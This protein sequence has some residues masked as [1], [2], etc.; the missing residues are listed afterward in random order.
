M[1]RAPCPSCPW[2]TSTP[3]GAFPG[4]CLNS[5]RLLAMAAGDLGEPVGPDFYDHLLTTGSAA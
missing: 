4:G 3:P 5:R 2:R 1:S